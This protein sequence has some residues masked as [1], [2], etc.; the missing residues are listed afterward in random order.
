ME[1]GQGHT[2][3][4]E[5]AAGG[6]SGI[7]GGRARKAEG[8]AK[9]TAHQEERERK[10]WERDSEDVGERNKQS[11]FEQRNAKW[12]AG[13]G[14]IQEVGYMFVLQD[15]GDARSGLRLAGVS[16]NVTSAGW[17]RH[18]RYAEDLR[19][20]DI[21]SVFN[22]DCAAGVRALV[23]CH[24]A[25]LEPSARGR[26][27]IVS[28]DFCPFPEAQHE[29]EEVLS[30]SIAFSNPG[31][32]LLEVE[33]KHGPRSA[34]EG[35][36]P[37]LMQVAQVLTC[38]STEATPEVLAGSVCDS[39]ARSLPGYDRVMVYRFTEDKSGEMI[40]EALRPGSHID[41]YLNV[42]FP[43]ADVTDVARNVLL[44]SRTRYI[45]D[46][47]M[48]GAPVRLHADFGTGLR[49]DL[50]RSTLKAPSACHIQFLRNIGVKASLTTAIVVD[51]ELWGM[52]SF[53]SYTRAVTPTVEERTLVEMAADFTGMKLAGYSRDRAAAISLTLT[54]ILE[55]LG[56]YTRIQDFLS[57]EHRALAGILEVDTIVLCEQSRAVTVYGNKQLSLSM[58]ECQVL[59]HDHISRKAL[60]FR[61]KDARS[62]A[63]FSMKS[64]LVAFVRGGVHHDI[65]STGDPEPHML[66]DHADHPPRTYFG[67]SLPAAS[68]H[69]LP[70]TRATEALLGVVRHGVATHLYAEALPADL[71]EII[72]HVSHELRTPFH[73]VMGSLEMLEEGLTR[74]G[75]E[76]RQSVIRSAIACGKCM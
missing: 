58:S 2:T 25:R 76:E 35:S 20:S 16:A 75:A 6:G 67:Q 31:V 42:R 15:Y 28:A 57:A 36:V 69:F 30:C 45:G 1:G 10:E 62:I 50:S 40:H 19:G 61:T 64:F 68:P 13:N 3:R 5:H 74:M 56:R 48:E 46:T 47:S 21:V 11:S 70:W 41:S 52:F 34:C 60:A 22:E 24:K 54:N 7:D 27:I 59:S 29:A 26:E 18:E 43:A 33:L 23:R 4:A 49:L 71:E 9:G 17:W 44:A 72:A 66:G 12:F 8:D 65:D 73:G 55:K 53:H 63:F 51:N 32:Y 14:M 37:G 38:V 39:L